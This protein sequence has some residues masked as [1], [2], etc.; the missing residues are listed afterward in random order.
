MLTMREIEGLSGSE[1]TVEEFEAR[2]AQM[3]PMQLAEVGAKLGIAA[4]AEDLFAERIA[5]LEGSVRALGD[6]VSAQ[7][8]R[9]LEEVEETKVVLLATLERLEGKVGRSE[10]QKVGLVRPA[11]DTWEAWEQLQ[12]ERI[13]EAQREVEHVVVL[14]RPDFEPKE[15][16]ALAHYYRLERPVTPS[17]GIVGRRDLAVRWAETLKRK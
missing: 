14:V 16:P 13:R 11:G 12:A 3:S 9:V 10:R 8:A 1:E 6:R 7:T 15:R 17:V 4:S 5:A 2:L